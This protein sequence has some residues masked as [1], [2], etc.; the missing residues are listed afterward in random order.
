MNNNKERARKFNRIVLAWFKKHGRNLP[1]RRTQ[2]PYRIFVSEVMLQQTQV[3][4]VLPK[5]REFLK[6]FP[7]ARVLAQSSLGDVLRVWSGLG[8]N[9]RAKYLW[10]CARAIDR[11]H[12]GKFPH[13]ISALLQLPGIGRS[14]AA[15]LSA[16][17]F[18]KDEPMIDT[19][20]RRILCR[21]FFKK[22]ILSDTALY[23]FARS[24]VP[25][26]KGKEW[27]WALM[28]IGALYCKANGHR[29]ECP[30][31]AFHGTVDGFRYRKPQSRFAGSRRFWRGQILALLAKTREG[32]ALTLLYKK[33]GSGLSK[34]VF[35]FVAQSLEREKLVRKDRGRFRFP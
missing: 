28:D 24:I 2:N 19:N 33:L 5:Y 20:V 10:E 13:D 15:A 34:K 4:R 9:R 6:K 12:N 14:T 22:H 32:Y 29:P 25:K 26:G 31:A 3:G 16:F 1:W 35:A 7:N 23:K 11:R 27:N 30:L 21:A 8:Y 17:A 18:G